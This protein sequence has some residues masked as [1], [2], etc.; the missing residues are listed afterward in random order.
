MRSVLAPA[1]VAVYYAAVHNISTAMLAV[2]F[3]MCCK[4][5]L[6]SVRAAMAVTPVVG[7]QQL[8]LLMVVLMLA[9]GGCI[10]QKQHAWHTNAYYQ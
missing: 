1:T 8:L 3:D 10:C 5:A 7:P 2:W 6:S 9:F 4:S